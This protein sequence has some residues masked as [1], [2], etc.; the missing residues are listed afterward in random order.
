MNLQQ[1][2]KKIRRNETIDIVSFDSD[3]MNEL[4][5]LT[6]TEKG[7]AFEFVVNSYFMFFPY[8][9]NNYT[10]LDSSLNE[11][12]SVS[13]IDIGKRGTSGYGGHAV[14]FVAQNQTDKSYLVGS[15]KYDESGWDG[16]DGNSLMSWVNNH[17]SGSKN[18]LVAITS[19]TDNLK[20][21][22][23]FS[24]LIN[25]ETLCGFWKDL[26]DKLDQNGNSFKALENNKKKYLSPRDAV[27]R[28]IIDE[29]R[30][31]LAN[32][33]DCWWNVVPRTGKLYMSAM[34]AKD[35]DK[36]CFTTHFPT[37]TLQSIISAFQ[38]ARDYSDHKIFTGDTDIAEIKKAGK[39]VLIVSA[40]KLKESD[41]VRKFVKNTKF[42]FFI[43]DEVHHGF[44]ADVMQELMNDINSSKFLFMSGTMDIVKAN[45]YKYINRFDIKNNTINW[46][47][48]DTQICKTGNHPRLKPYENG[49]NIYSDFTEAKYPKLNIVHLSPNKVLRDR[50][51]DIGAT[52]E[53][54]TWEKIYNNSAMLKEYI[55]ILL[56]GSLSA[57]DKK[58][59]GNTIMPHTVAYDRKFI[60]W[61]CPD[62]KS[63]K[64]LKEACEELKNEGRMFD[65]RE[66][67]CFNSTDDS[68]GVLNEE[69]NKL[70][71]DDKNYLLIFCGQGT[72]GIT[73][74]NMPVAIIGRDINSYTLWCQTVF[75][76]MTASDGVAY[77]RYVYDLSFGHTFVDNITNMIKNNITDKSSLEQ[78]KEFF[79]C[80]KITDGFSSFSYET[81]EELRTE[82]Y[83]GRTQFLFHGVATNEDIINA[84]SGVDDPKAI[85]SLIKFDKLVIGED[86]T[87][88]R[89]S[90]RDKRNN[91]KKEDDNEK[92]KK[93]AA[94]FI[95]K[96]FVKLTSGVS[97][98]SFE[99]C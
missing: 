21:V 44:E 12:N 6:L 52:E 15:S 19:N 55:R 51:K 13:N 99:S 36:V 39:Y 24:H 60:A 75:R 57:K 46:S 37:D 42:D 70:N 32:A 59:I 7:Y 23:E 80:V 82:V 33:N 97:D 40:Q 95:M 48:L 38:S 26:C 81:F 66:I 4:K 77:D 94:I 87:K 5:P 62:T 90:K 93:A 1:A 58:L 47:Y 8:N 86:K 49:S 18:E 98:E 73:F 56:G 79:N 65:E 72:T 83:K 30:K 71:S 34:I 45:G 69:L 17:I 76:V 3:F 88:G 16:M 9:G 41:K 35:Y 85:S 11:I 64:L 68:D 61:Y 14:D 63:Q 54:Q 20:N 10:L 92:A 91:S 78:M 50:L 2:I 31:I 43:Y 74:K 84:I 27:Q 89:S 29:S 22:K 28:M 25:L 67:L 53:E 96:E